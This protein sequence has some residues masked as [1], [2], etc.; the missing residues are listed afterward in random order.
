MMDGAETRIAR[1]LSEAVAI[2]IDENFDGFVVEGETPIALDQATDARQHFPSLNILCLVPHKME[3]AQPRSPSNRT[4]PWC[5]R[6]SRE[7]HWSAA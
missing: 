7:E 6:R 1:T 4:S 2:L 5:W 3:D